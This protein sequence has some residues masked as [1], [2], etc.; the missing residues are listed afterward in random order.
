MGSV[1]DAVGNTLLVPL[2]RVVPSGAARILAK[3]EWE[4]PTGSLKDRMAVAVVLRAE[5]D[6][7]LQSGDTVIEYTGGSTGTS[8]AFVC[9]A[10]G[11]PIHIV[12]SDAFSQEK[13]DHMAALGATL[14]LVPSD[15]G[16]TTKRLILAMIEEARRLSQ[17]P[18]TYWT[19][20]LHNQDSIAGYFSLGEEIWRQTNAASTPSCTR[21]GPERHH[22]ASPPCSGNATR[23]FTSRSSSPRNRRSCSAALRLR[24]ASRGWASDTHRPSGSRLW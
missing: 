6:G 18:H 1:L 13:R 19:D 11:Y 17:A 7:R 14:T 21:W 22:G 2:R 10:R 9:A 24:M 15:G 3:L 5:A 20:Q 4:S 8:L 23:A 16:R 12:T